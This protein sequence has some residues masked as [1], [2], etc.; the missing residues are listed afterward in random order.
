MRMFRGSWNPSINLFALSSTPEQ[1][2]LGVGACD[3]IAPRVMFAGMQ[4]IDTTWACL[5]CFR[6]A[7]RFLFKEIAYLDTGSP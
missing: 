1:V 5:A 7:A 6:R 2:F 4:R 3:G